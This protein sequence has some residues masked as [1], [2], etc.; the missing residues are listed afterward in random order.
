MPNNIMQL[1]FDNN[2]IVDKTGDTLFDTPTTVEFVDS[3]LEGKGYKA[4]KTKSATCL[5]NK[6][7]FA[8]NYQ[9]G[10]T[11]CCWFNRL[12]GYNWPNKGTILALYSDLYFEPITYPYWNTALGDQQGLIFYFSNWINGDAYNGT[13]TSGEWAWIAISFCPNRIST[14]LNGKRK[15]F[16]L[17]QIKFSTEEKDYGQNLCLFNYPNRDPHN[18]YN[19][20]I[21]DVCLFPGTVDPDIGELKVPTDYVTQNDLHLVDNWEIHSKYKLLSY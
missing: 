20:S 10:F 12:N 15:S 4:L 16:K 2:S 19:G 8:I 3:P 11:F 17:D 5:V 7:S 14:Y 21:F 6:G 1:R 9:K 13:Y 18:Y